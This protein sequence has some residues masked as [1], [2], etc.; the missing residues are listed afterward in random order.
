VTPEPVRWVWRALRGRAKVKRKDNSLV[1]HSFAQ[2]IG[3]A[4]R[5]KALLAR[6]TLVWTQREEHWLGLSVGIISCIHEE[7]NKTAAPFGIET[8]HPF[9]DRRLVEFC[10]ALPPEQKLHQ[11]W[12]R[13]ILRRAMTNILPDEIQWRVGKSNLSAN[14]ARS[15]FLFERERLKEI[16]F[17]DPKLIEDYDYVDIGTLQEEYRQRDANAIWPAVILDLWLRQ[18]SLS[19]ESCEN[20]RR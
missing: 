3:F 12:P 10:L 15:L 6:Y 8:R 17:K 16:I 14:F 13:W 18:A 1:N 5:T 11:G 9:W 4:E 7:L 2:R 20:G 19:P